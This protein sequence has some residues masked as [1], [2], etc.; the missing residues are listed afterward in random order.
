MEARQRLFSSSYNQKEDNNQ[1]EINKQ[2][3]A[4]GNQ[5]A[6]NSNYKGLKEKINQNYQ[7]SKLLDHSGQLRKTEE[8]QRTLG[9]ELAAELGGLR[10]KG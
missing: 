8:T 1:S 9:E 10:M 3:K 5:T 6:R 7:T 2:P 4:P